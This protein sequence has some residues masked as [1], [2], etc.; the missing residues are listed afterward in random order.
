M[1][2][3]LLTWLAFF[4][5]TQSR[6]LVGE[7]CRPQWARSKTNQDNSPTDCDGLH[8]KCSPTG[9]GGF[10]LLVPSSWWCLGEVLESLGGGAVLKELHHG[11]LGRL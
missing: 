9:S 11:G 4:T 3:S 10:E 2:P 8:R 7:W 5:V 6:A 1:L